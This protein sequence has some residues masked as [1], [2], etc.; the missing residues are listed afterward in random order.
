[1]QQVN[2]SKECQELSALCRK[3]RELLEKGAYDTCEELIRASME[4]YPHAPQPHNLFGLLLEKAGDSR[5]AMK[6]F[7][8]S[9]ALDPAYLPARRNL[10]RYA[11]FHTRGP[12][13]FDEA[14]CPENAASGA[15]KVSYDA[16]GVGH[17]VVCGK[18]HFNISEIPVL[19]NA[20]VAGKKL[21]E[22]DLPPDVIIGCLLRGDQCIVPCG[23]TTLLS[24]DVLILISADKQEV[25]AIRKLT[26]KG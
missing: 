21:W 15:V 22:T 9:Q 19:P 5:A 26:G 12:G 11:S 7:R 25:P 17:A 18:G 13:I 16:Q 20:P 6:H 24:G 23:D 14:D 1:M 8:A 10:E 2:A 3:A 4:K